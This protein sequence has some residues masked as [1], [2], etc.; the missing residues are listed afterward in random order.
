MLAP[1]SRGLRTRDIRGH[2]CDVYGTE[3]SPELVSRVA[4]A[5]SD[6]VRGWQQRPLDEVYPIVY[7]DA[8]Y[9]PIREGGVVVKKAAYLAMGVTL[10][11]DREVLGLWLQQAE[12]AKFWLQ[13]LTELKN[14]GV[15]DIFIACVDGLIGQSAP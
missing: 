2:L 11:G 12:G 9:L 6:Q 5:V 10:E 1:Y 3:I 4:D 15:Q 7:L 14:R 8:L 13:V